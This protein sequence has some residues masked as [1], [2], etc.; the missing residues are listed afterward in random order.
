MMYLC[1][2]FHLPSCN[3]PLVTAIKTNATKIF[4][5]AAI[6]FFDIL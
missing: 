3:D 1:G 6:L 2:I 4:H 5:A